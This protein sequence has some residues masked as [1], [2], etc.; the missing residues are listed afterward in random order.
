MDRKHL[1]FLLRGGHFNMEDRT[2]LGIWPHDPIAVTECVSVIREHLDL[3]GFYPAPYEP[4]VPGE[5]AGDVCA[6]EKVSR[7]R[8]IFHSH[9]AAPL[10]PYELRG[11]TS[12]R[13]WSASR[14]IRR[15]LKWQ[16]CLPGDLDGWKIS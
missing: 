10:N 6:L 8:Y 14:A 9:N 5:F 11:Q 1:S 13:F 3:M 16:L 4:P 15:Y 7:F 2:E 12:K